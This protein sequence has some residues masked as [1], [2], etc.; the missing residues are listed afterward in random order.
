MGTMRSAPRF[1]D[2]SRNFWADPEIE[3]E[4]VSTTIR[5]LEECDAGH[6]ALYYLEKFEG[7]EPF[8]SKGPYFEEKDWVFT[9]EV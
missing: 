6:T 2:G 4:I 8:L 5:V 1:P 3:G 7:S 9:H